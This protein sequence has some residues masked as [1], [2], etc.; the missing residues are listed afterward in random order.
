MAWTRYIILLTRDEDE[1]H[2]PSLP[3]TVGNSQPIEDLVSLLKDQAYGKSIKV[4]AYRLHQ[5]V[6]EET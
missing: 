5:V 6:A 4:A 2:I 3:Y 1:K